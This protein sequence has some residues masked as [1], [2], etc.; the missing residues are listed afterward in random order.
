MAV[1]SG[2]TAVRDAVGLLRFV[3]RDDEMIKSAGNRI[4]PNEIEEAITAGGETSE[5][6]A[7]GVPDERQGQAIVVVAKGDGSAE[8]VLRE[9]LRRDLPNFMHP[10][11]YI[12]LAE[13]PR[14]ANGKL[15]RAGLRGMT[16]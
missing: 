3:G 6:V 14:N 12:W 1:W 15:D 9:R 7:I 2:D 16:S 10:A 13:L 5:A 11:R 4:S 8:P